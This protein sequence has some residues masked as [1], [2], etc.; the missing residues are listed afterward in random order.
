MLD[1]ILSRVFLLMCLNSA[2]L[3]KTGVSTICISPLVLQLITDL[4]KIN[5][6]G[7]FQFFY[8]IQPFLSLH[9]SKALYTLFTLSFSF[10]LLF[11]SVVQSNVTFSLMHYASGYLLH[12]QCLIVPWTLD[13][14]MKKLVFTCCWLLQYY[15]Y[16]HKMIMFLRN[17]Y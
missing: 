3:K 1:I 4:E 10:L 15:D 11:G 2:W 16:H 6:H 9:E 12:E 8:P 13:L 7:W 17:I 14:W 5:S